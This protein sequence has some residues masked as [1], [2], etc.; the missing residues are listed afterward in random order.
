[1]SNRKRIADAIMLELRTGSRHAE[2]AQ[3]AH[4]AFHAGE[5][6]LAQSTLEIA[7]A[8]AQEA[9]PEFGNYVL[10]D[11]NWSRGGAQ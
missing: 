1:M 4:I 3:L 5:R 8:L 10:C 6:E 2:L 11:C 9:D 7:D